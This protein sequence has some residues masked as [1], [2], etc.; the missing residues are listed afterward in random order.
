MSGKWGRDA[1][2]AH[3]ALALGLALGV[4]CFLA[5]ALDGAVARAQELADNTG[6]APADEL[7]LEHARLL[8]ARANE[9][10]KSFESE[11]DG[12]ATGAQAL[13]A[14]RARIASPLPPDAPAAAGPAPGDAA[15]ALARAEADRAATRAQA[16]S[17]R[18]QALVD[19]GTALE[20]RARQL[21]TALAAARA[22]TAALGE[23]LTPVREL[24]ARVKSGKLASA[25][26]PDG[27]AS[28]TLASRFARGK[29]AETS[30][31][32]EASRVADSRRT[33][34]ERLA[35]ARAALAAAEG[36]KARAGR[37]LRDALA[38]EALEK[39]LAGKERSKLVALLSDALLERDRLSHGVYSGGEEAPP[40]V[41]DFVHA[42]DA[43]RSLERALESQAPPTLDG[44]RVESKLPRVIPAERVLRYGEALAAW[45]DA[46][47]ALSAQL[48]TALA[49][50]VDKADAASKT[51]A[52]LDDELLHIDV[53][54]ELLRRARGE[55]TVPPA[56][57]PEE[58]A[59][60]RDVALRRTDEAA[61]ARDH[62]RARRAE[63]EKQAQDEREAARRERDRLPEL[64]QAF[65]SA[66]ESAR[67][68][69]E[70]EALATSDV[71]TRLREARAGREQWTSA[72]DLARAD[73]EASEAA[74]TSSDAVLDTLEDP[75]ARRV[76]QESPDERRRIVVALSK[77]VGIAPPPDVAADPPLAPPAVANVDPAASSKMR[78][79]IDERATFFSTRSQYFDQEVAELGRLAVAL[80]REER[81]LGSL[82]RAE[83]AAREA[84]QKVYGAALE[85][86]TRAGLNQ[87]ARADLPE[88]THQLATRDRIQALDAELARIQARQASVAERRREAARLRDETGQ[89]G[90]LLAQGFANAGR[91]LETLRERAQLETEFAA[92]PATLTDT[93][94]KRLDREVARHLDGDATIAERLLSVVTSERADS[95]TD[96][97]RSLYAD[98]VDLERKR[99]NVQ[100]RLVLTRSLIATRGDERPIDAALEPLERHRVERLDAD[101][102]EGRIRAGLVP[103]S[104]EVARQKLQALGRPV[105]APEAIG[106]DGIATAADR[107]FL[108]RCR[109]S[110]ERA[111]LRT[112]ESRL[113]PIGLDGE[114]GE[115]RDELGAL[116][117]TL[118]ALGREEQRLVGRGR[119]ASVPAG[120][121]E[122]PAI[123][124]EIGAARAERTAA[125]ERSALS[126][127]LKLVLIP[128][129]A[130][131]LWRFGRR[132]GVR[133]IER[134]RSLNDPSTTALER[135][136]RAQTLAHVI[137]T[138]WTLAIVSAA[139]MSWLRELGFNVTAILASAGVVGLAIAF[140]AQALVK[141]FFAGFFIL[142]ENQYKIGDTIKIGESTGI[143]ERVTLRLTVLRG[144]DGTVFYIPNGSVERVSNSS[145]GWSK[146]ILAVQIAY[147]ENTDRVFKLLREVSAE[148]DADETAGPKL[149]E[150]PEV[151]GIQSMRDGGVTVGLQLKTI[152]GEQDVVAREARLRIRRAFG[153]AGIRVPDPAPDRAF[154]PA[155]PPPA[156]PPPV[157]PAPETPTASPPPVAADSPGPV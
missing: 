77:V 35:A 31:G 71:V 117:A 94:R 123:G 90:G 133:L 53:I 150:P 26:L 40:W 56:L 76:R 96:L 59:R 14:V 20:A 112:L 57:A 63:V 127:L 9:A 124:G 154:V 125:L 50:L 87:L 156:S 102:A 72:I 32:A 111:F 105:P 30:W 113:S 114:L 74:V 146:A 97:L 98:L 46:R 157:A 148:L 42:R 135:E 149:L 95:I 101:D 19:E 108:L 132:A 48:A 141:D 13:E 120:A 7:V 144:D 17:A 73:V 54:A 91:L 12:L 10:E 121:S 134:A 66:V 55:R 83:S 153:K 15:S 106:A 116:G 25:K 100:D 4:G 78:A 115:V 22:L 38:R 85:L 47:A 44:V 81:A 49:G 65:R 107:L 136:Q 126:S 131:L 68:T 99:K 2:R 84:A 155:E 33:A 28:A 64:Q 147:E 61:S 138:A 92:A 27:A 62:A 143:V 67:W 58:L 75:A 23:A 5:H 104:D 118:D 128:A 145:R 70:V 139:G 41:V 69:S 45:H 110:G 151:L 109:A 152:A 119:D 93:E 89:L 21:D 130:L 80:E 88:G 34:P 142:V 137:G 51:S 79:R 36:E 86:E 18:V 1:S 6:P 52:A 37:R 16:T 129:V 29:D 60:E 103:A 24:E 122:P 140:G 39:E 8:L 11:R 43:V 3:A 82:V